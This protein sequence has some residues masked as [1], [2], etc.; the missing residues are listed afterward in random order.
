[1]M[2]AYKK[3]SDQESSISRHGSMAFVALDG[4]SSC[5]SHGWFELGELSVYVKISSIP[6]TRGGFL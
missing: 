5:S 1:M 6:R 3:A 4:N 2:S